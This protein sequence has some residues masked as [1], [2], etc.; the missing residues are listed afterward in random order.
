MDGEAVAAAEMS[1][2]W[3][4]IIALAVGALAGWLAGLVVRGMGFGLLGNIVV[5]IIGAVIAAFLFPWLGFSLGGGFIGAI[6]EPM[7]GA[8]IFLVI[9]G[10]IRRA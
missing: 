9:L 5:G 1:T 4:V 8:I 6:V 3:V 7:L 10:L 2:L